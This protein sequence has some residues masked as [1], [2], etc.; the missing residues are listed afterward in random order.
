[1][2]PLQGIRVLERRAS[3]PFIACSWRIWAQN[4]FAS[5]VPTID[6]DHVFRAAGSWPGRGMRAR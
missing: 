5:N 2:C 3:A 1:M 4:W 6:T